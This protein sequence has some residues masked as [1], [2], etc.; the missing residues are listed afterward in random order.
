[1]DDEIIIPGTI[2]IQTKEFVPILQKW[3]RQHRGVPWS[4]F[5]RGTIRR[6]PEIRRLAGKRF[7]HLVNGDKNAA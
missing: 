7:S 3:R 5:L 1:M 2:G 6:D 4:E